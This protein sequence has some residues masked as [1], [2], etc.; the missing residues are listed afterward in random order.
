M[1]FVSKNIPFSQI[2]AYDICRAASTLF[3]TN[4]IYKKLNTIK[5]EC[6]IDYFIINL[7]ASKFDEN[8]T[9]YISDELFDSNT[10]N[11]CFIAKICLVN[12]IELIKELLDYNN[13]LGL[14]YVIV[15][16]TKL[17]ENFNTLELYKKYFMYLESN[18]L[19]FLSCGK[20]LAYTLDLNF[21]TINNINY[22]IE[23]IDNKFYQQIAFN[24]KLSFN[25]L[26][27]FIIDE[28]LNSLSLKSYEF[29]I[30]LLTYR[31]KSIVIPISIFINN[32]ENYPI[33][34]KNIQL[35]VKLLLKYEVDII[36]ENDL[37]FTN[38]VNINWDDFNY[39]KLNNYYLYIEHLFI[40]HYEYTKEDMITNCYK[41]VLQTPLQPLRDNLCSKIYESF[42]LDIVKYLKYHEAIYKAL[43]DIYN[44]II[45]L[46]LQTYNIN[47]LIV[48]AGRGPLVDKTLTTIEDLNI[49]TFNIYI[50][51]K[52]KFAV[53]TLRLKYSK[54]IDQKII[55]LIKDDIRSYI[56]TNTKKYDLII[57][58]LLGSFGDNELSPECLELSETVLTDI[59]AMIPT[60]HK[61]YVTPVSYPYNYNKIKHISDY[62]YNQPFVVLPHKIY[63]PYN[64]VKEL[65]TFNYPDKNSKFNISNSVEFDNLHFKNPE[66]NSVYIHGFMGFFSTVLYKDVY[67]TI[68][69]NEKTQNM[70]SWF[71]IFFPIKRPLKIDSNSNNLTI[72]V[73]R[74]SKTKVWYEWSIVIINKLNESI[75]STSG[76]SNINGEYFSIGL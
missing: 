20:Y 18:I 60:S 76:T 72:N 47:I 57:S 46:K 36:L 68:I 37:D 17:Y 1:G 73:K 74:I 5:N 19:L 59:G 58:E 14:K 16:T 71:P 66:Y 27:E 43:N 41:D 48:G 25:C 42:E 56:K 38:N 28:K 32:K 53:N 52:N 65:F 8:Q 12:D 9:N 45:T 6:R 10:W 31:I 62:N 4:D 33:L 50:V 34:P 3:E 40:N 63:Y 24:L 51:E 2:I 21:N 29:L 69:Y 75:I 15:D 22:I 70:N 61:S 35:I 55:F 13:H 7:I 30:Q 11:N 64:S 26:N 23:I 44:K 54:H 49:K 39:N 67:L